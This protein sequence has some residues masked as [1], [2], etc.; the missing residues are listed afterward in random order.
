MRAEGAEGD[1]GG[2]RTGANAPGHSICSMI[3]THRE[4][5]GVTSH[6]AKPVQPSTNL[7]EQIV[8]LYARGVS[9]RHPGER[10]T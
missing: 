9:T 10:S 1:E 3:L 7:E 4:L 8:N 6:R 2:G 5:S